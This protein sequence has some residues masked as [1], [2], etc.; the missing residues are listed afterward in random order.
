MHGV[1]IGT[2]QEDCLAL[3][4]RTNNKAEHRLVGLS[5]NLLVVEE[6]KEETDT[7]CLITFFP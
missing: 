3:K 4:I 5:K 1:L 2:I 7:S 6:Q